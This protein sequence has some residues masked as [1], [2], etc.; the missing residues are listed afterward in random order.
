MKAALNL[1]SIF[2]LMFAGMAWSVGDY[3]AMF[4]LIVCGILF[5]LGGFDD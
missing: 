5:M 3:W 4:W 1:L 2:S